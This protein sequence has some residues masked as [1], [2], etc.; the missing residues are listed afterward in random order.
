M[1]TQAGRTLALG[2]MLVSRVTGLEYL[3]VAV[4]EDVATLVLLHERHDPQQWL[5][6]RRTLTPMETPRGRDNESTDC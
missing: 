4:A 6:V 1:T 3:V 5:V 2:E